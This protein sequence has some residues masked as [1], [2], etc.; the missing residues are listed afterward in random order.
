[1]TPTDSKP[2]TREQ[3]LANAAE[4][5]KS[6]IILKALMMAAGTF[7]SRILGLIRE[8]ALAA[9][10]DR[11]VT[12]AWTAA[13][14]LPNLFR[15]ILGEGSLSVTLQPILIQ[16]QMEDQKTG[17]RRAKSL[18]ES[19]HLL[20]IVALTVLTVAGI[21]FS[22]PILR[23]VL[24]QSYTAKVQ[25]LALTVR[26]A[27]IMFGFLFFICLFAYYMAILN[28]VGSFGWPAAA[29]VLF[30]VS[31]I[32][33]TFVPTD[34][35]PVK[36]DTLAWGV[37]AGGFMQMSALILPLRKKGLLP[38]FRWN[39][40][41]PDVLT[42][43]RN[44]APGLFGLGLIQ[45]TILIN[46]HFASSLGTGAISYIYWADRLLELPLSLVSVSLG[47][48][49]M[50]A[51]T[52][53]WMRGEKAKTAEVSER[54]LS[55]NFFVGSM[56]SVGLYVL[57]LP[58][59]K[60]LFQ[61]G[62]FTSEDSLQVASVLQVYSLTLIPVSA[63]RVL[64]PAYYAV[65]NTWFP[66]ASAAFALLVHIII[67]PKLMNDYGLRGLNFSSF[68]S[69]GIN[70]IFLLSAYSFFI[71]SFPWKS[72]IFKVFK[73]VVASGVMIFICQ[74][75]L[76]HMAHEDHFL[77]W[78]FLLLVASLLGIT[79]YLLTSLIL[80]HPDMESF[81]SRINSLLRARLNKRKS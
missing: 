47:T 45:V 14:R 32:I 49:L 48:A 41:N 55:L 60:I 52:E 5:R 75:V 74:F 2:I 6:S 62:H 65:K 23:M 38:G 80:K 17:G 71:T 28:S 29:P 8:M 10:F 30:N 40:K 81:T 9:F 1:M 3:I 50:P 11:A 13:F 36:G 67:A 54:Y 68:I 66:A 44:M 31:L 4:S 70:I 26:L 73:T 19:M 79:G 61:R 33:S 59:V 76:G 35:L 12:D 7:S 58:I 25:A 27:Q 15:R 72:F 42:I 77:E 69:A 51:L 21:I 34:W 63:I 37:L 56:A 64:V 57:A 22:E 78:L 46:T 39:P 16:A 18:L 53:Y 24:D 20:L 43:L